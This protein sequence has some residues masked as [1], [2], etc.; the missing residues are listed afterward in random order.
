MAL[1]KKKYAWWLTY[2]QIPG[3]IRT[4]LDHDCETTNELTGR[5]AIYAWI[6]ENISTLKLHNTS[7]TLLLL[8]SH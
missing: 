8:V 1:I 3:S 7:V 5:V 6:M 4:T 2:K